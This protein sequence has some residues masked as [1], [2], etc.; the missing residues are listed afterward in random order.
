MASTKDNAD[1]EHWP[2]TNKLSTAKAEPAAQY[3]SHNGLHEHTYRPASG[4][5]DTKPAP[6]TPELVAAQQPQFAM[7]F[8]YPQGAYMPYTAAPAYYGYG[9]ARE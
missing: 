2:D 7:P 4:A 6:K 3:T 5:K 1:Y 9:G 8:A